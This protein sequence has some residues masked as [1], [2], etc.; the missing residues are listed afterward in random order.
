MA[1]AAKA[2][3]GADGG[4]GDQVGLK[5]ELGLLNGV[6]IIV[7]IIIGAGIFV[8][9]TGVV[10]SS[11]SAGMSIIVWAACGLMSLV[12]AMCYAELGTMIPK[13]GGD[14]AYISQIYGPMM[15]F[16]F[17]WVSLLITQPVHNAIQSI[18]FANYI[19]APIFEGCDS[20]DSATRLLAAGLLCKFL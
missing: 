17:L 16:L 2:A 14:Y 15:G 10:R 13:S 7:G 19:L 9:P 3:A 8:S 11:G 18:T 6:G 4:G 12:G 20:P 1:T 5:R